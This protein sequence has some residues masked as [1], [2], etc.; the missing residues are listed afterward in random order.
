M[1]EL[2]PECMVRRCHDFTLLPETIATLLST[3][4]HQEKQLEDL[5]VAISACT[6][7]IYLYTV[8]LERAAY[9][10]EDIDRDQELAPMADFILKRMNEANQSAPKNIQTRSW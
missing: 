6:I 2:L 5:V 9:R 3:A 7:P 8:L 4:K 10:M 1:G